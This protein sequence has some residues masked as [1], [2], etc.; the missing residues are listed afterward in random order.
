MRSRSST[1][2]RLPW[3]APEG[4]TPACMRSRRSSSTLVRDTSPDVVLRSLNGKLPPEIRVLSAEQV[5]ASFHA[6]FNAT[7]K[8]YRYQMSNADV[9]NPFERAY[10]WHV[11]GPLD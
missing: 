10:V 3:P 5:P 9:L 1:G 11:P 7:L 6:R 2:A 4:P 8:R